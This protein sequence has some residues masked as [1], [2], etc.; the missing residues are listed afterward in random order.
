MVFGIFASL[1]SF[2][3][4][5]IAERV[6]AGLARARA[7]GTKLGRES[8]R[9]AATCLYERGMSV[10]KIAK[11]LGIGIGGPLRKNPIR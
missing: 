4:E 10:R 8:V 11:E 2:E 7:S 3:R 9:A 1:A 5:M 6:K